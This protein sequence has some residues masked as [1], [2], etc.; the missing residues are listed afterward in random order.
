MYKPSF[1]VQPK[2]FSRTWSS[3][4]KILNY[5]VIEH[6]LN[7]PLANSTKLSKFEQ[8]E[9]KCGELFFV[10]YKAF[11]VGKFGSVYVNESVARRRL[12]TYMCGVR[13]NRSRATVRR[14]VASTRAVHPGQAHFSGDMWRRNTLVF[15]V[16][17]VAQV[18]HESE[19]PLE[20]NLRLI[21]LLNNKCMV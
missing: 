15:S 5:V 12:P 19:E 2:P 21:S 6:T 3:P 14:R 1:Y 11:V 4:L 8:N 13:D 16:V 17:E 10:I 18:K 7:G 20:L 9:M